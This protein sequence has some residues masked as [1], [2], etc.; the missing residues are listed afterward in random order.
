MGYLIDTFDASERWACPPPLDGEMKKGLNPK[1]VWEQP[2]ECYD[3]FGAKVVD[4]LLIGLCREKDFLER[5][6]FVFHSPEKTMIYRCKLMPRLM[7][8]FFQCSNQFSKGEWEIGSDSSDVLC[9]SFLLSGAWIWIAYF[10][11]HL[12]HLLPILRL[13]PALRLKNGMGRWTGGE[14]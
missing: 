11:S 8:F 12:F 1:K 4:F 5:F 9:F 14:H 2:L 3:C 13:L 7:A 10:F 6:I